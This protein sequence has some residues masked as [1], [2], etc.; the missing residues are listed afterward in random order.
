DL[1][2]RWPFAEHGLRRVL[3]E[4]TAST[5]FD[6]QLRVGETADLPLA[7]LFP[8]WLLCPPHMSGWRLRRCLFDHGQLPLPRITDKRS[9]E[10]GLRQVAPVFQRH[11]RFHRSHL[12]SRRVEDRRKIG[13]PIGLDRVFRRDVG[14][15]A[16]VAESQRLTIPPRRS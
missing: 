4:R 8:Y 9:N 7:G 2:M 13:L 12:E 1:G 6:R 5:A 15:P 10:F 16:T 3:V 14:L 11:L